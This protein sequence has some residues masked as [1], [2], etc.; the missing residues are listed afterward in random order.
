M[1]RKTHF[2]PQKALGSEI[3]KEL[4]V[5]FSR[6][7]GW[8]ERIIAKYPKQIFF[9]MLATILISAI[10]AFTVMRIK[11]TQPLPLYSSSVAPITQGFGQILGAGQALKKVLELQNQINLVLRKDSLTGNDSLLVKNALSQLESIHRELN[12]KKSE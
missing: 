6:F 11:K 1:Y 9:T 12:V 10:L 3:V 2:K 7:G 8:T 4:A 5:Y